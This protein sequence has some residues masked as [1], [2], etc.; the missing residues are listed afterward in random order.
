MGR[1]HTHATPVLRR[2]D[3]DAPYCFLTFDDGPDAQWTPRVL[4][5]LASAG[6]HATFFVL[7]RL[8]VQH[9]GLVR[10]AHALGHEIANHSYSHRHPW[11]LSRA[12]ARHEIRAGAQAIADVVGKRPRWYRPPHGRLGRHGLEA[13]ALEDQQIALWSVSAID[14]GPLASTQRIVG[15]LQ[16]LRSGDVALLHDGPLRHNRPDQTV[17]ALPRL[18]S[19]LSRAGLASSALP[20]AAIMGA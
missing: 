13:A 18:F 9:A 12:G 1:M 3:D 4:D 8:A 19:A 10:R 20:H 5:A 17:A 16:N 2:F 15:R 6:A 7:G 14:W 11:T